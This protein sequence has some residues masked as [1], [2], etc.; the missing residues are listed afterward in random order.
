MKKNDRTLNERQKRMR[1]KRT[2][3]GLIRRDVWAHEDDWAAIRALEKKLI[4]ER[5]LNPAGE[6]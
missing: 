5:D 1:E 3:L 4:K 6:S 2:T